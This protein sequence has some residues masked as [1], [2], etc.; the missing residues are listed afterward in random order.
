MCTDLD[1]KLKPTLSMGAVG[2]LTSE[3][4]FD[5][6]FWYAWTKF[7]YLQVDE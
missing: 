7:K 3:R 1:Q 2:L 5:L 4:N 6:S